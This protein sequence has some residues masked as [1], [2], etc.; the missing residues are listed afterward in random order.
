MNQTRNGYA[1][2]SSP[3]V[4]FLLGL[5]TQLWLWS[6]SS[7]HWDQ[8]HLYR[9][10]MDLAL[11]G[12]VSAF[13]KSMSGGGVI[14]GSLL[15]LIVGAPLRLW[16]DYRSP[17]LVVVIFHALAGLILWRVFQQALGSRFAS[18]YLGVYWL[19][20]WRLYHSGFIWEPN[21][22]L[23]P[24]AVH[25]WASWVQRREA[26]RWAS[27]VLGLT[28]LLAPQLHL[29]GVVLIL[30][31]VLLGWRRVVRLDPIGILS[32]AAL[33]TLT[34]LPTA[35]A[36]FAGELP[37]IAP[38]AALGAGF[39]KIYP[40]FK[41]LA[42]WLRLGSLD[43]GRRL[44]QVVFYP[45]NDPGPPTLLTEVLLTT[46]VVVAAASVL[47]ALVA[48][49]SYFRAAWRQREQSSAETFIQRYVGASLLT[50]LVAV[51]LTSQTV[52][53]WHALVIL[54]AAAVPV[55]AWCARL[56]ER[57]P[58]RWLTAAIVLF[59]LLRLP[60]VGILGYGHPMYRPPATPPPMEEL[61]PHDIDPSLRPGSF[62]EVES[63]SP[64]PRWKPFSG[65][66]HH[67]DAGAETNLLIAE[68]REARR[69]KSC[70]SLAISKCYISP[71]RTG[72]RRRTVRSVEQTSSERFSS[73]GGALKSS[74]RSTG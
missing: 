50:F 22:L 65:G 16:L 44:R 34:L 28:L 46:A 11:D 20:P 26:K 74:E 47:L 25:L 23:L 49:V 8:I 5:G 24:A 37:R 1:V 53:G 52:Q 55:A 36:F 13:A 33:G 62:G 63:W 38:S 59:L 32:G 45:G 57:S 70:R 40:L 68:M 41:A 60:L 9:L 10:G 15:Q 29:S 51:G 72:V 73:N 18:L 2:L 42:Y 17:G 58:S 3:L 19:S 4:L 43:V 64:G 35:A 54:H 56:L 6:R 27:L 71:P 12:E 30:L 39:L 66:R 31:T 69:S 7:Y 14:P 21:Y 61:R 67:R 48:S